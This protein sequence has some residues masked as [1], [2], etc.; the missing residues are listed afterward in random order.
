MIVFYTLSCSLLIYF[1]YVFLS[2]VM[3]FWSNRVS[4]FNM[5]YIFMS[6]IFFSEGGVFE[7]G[8]TVFDTYS[9]IGLFWGR[10]LM[11]LAPLLFIISLS[12]NYHSIVTVGCKK[13]FFSLR[14]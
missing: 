8:Q 6:Y 9:K 7:V 11:I 10:G 1:W 5:S 13:F 2:T 3:H 14:A 12:Y 4:I